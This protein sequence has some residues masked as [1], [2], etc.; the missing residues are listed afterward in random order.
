MS[1]K[2]P[3]TL[4]L[5]M[6][7]MCSA[8]SNPSYLAHRRGFRKKIEKSV[9]FFRKGVDSFVGVGLYSATTRAGRR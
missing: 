8:P 7:V 1:F 5:M 3:H 9:I 2:T 4:D 6:L